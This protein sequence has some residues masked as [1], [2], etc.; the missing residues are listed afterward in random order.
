[1]PPLRGWPLVRHW[2]RWKITLFFAVLIYRII[3]PDVEALTRKHHW[4]LAREKRRRQEARN[5]DR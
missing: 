1:M 4:L 2:L 5:A 3:F